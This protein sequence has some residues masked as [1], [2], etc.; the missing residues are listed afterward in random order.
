MFGE[1][2]ISQVEISNHPIDSQ[3]SNTCDGHQV[4]D[5]A[6]VVFVCRHELRSCCGGVIY[7]G[8]LKFPKHQFFWGLL[9]FVK[10]PKFVPWQS[11]SYKS[12]CNTNIA[13]HF[14]SSLELWS[15]VLGEMWC[16]KW[17]VQP[18]TR[19]VYHCVK[20]VKVSFRL[21]CHSILEVVF[22][23]SD[24]QH[25]DRK[26]QMRPQAKAFWGHPK[27]LF[28]VF[29]VFFFK[30]IPSHGMNIT[31]KNPTEFRRRFFLSLFPFAS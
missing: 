27:K 25:A 15:R 14:H 7:L 23:K 28:F 29:L 22:R 16:W 26:T 30:R 19:L 8:A 31:M 21:A 17:V 4:P 20:S 11:A 18:P 5:S 10:L 6:R 13:D 2:T 1:P 3:S 12:D 9:R 24:P